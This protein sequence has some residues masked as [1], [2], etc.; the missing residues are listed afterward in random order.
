[1]SPFLARQG[2]EPNTPIELLY[3]S[4][5]QEDLGGVDL[6]D[7]VM[8]NSDRVE[9]L[10]ERTEARLRETAIKRKHTWDKK[11]D[12]IWMR[13]SGSNLKLDSSWEG[14]YTVKKP[15]VATSTKMLLCDE[16]YNLGSCV[17]RSSFEFQFQII[18]PTCYSML[19]ISD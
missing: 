13:K 16:L 7:W 19:A 6:D 14:P 8:M 4:W 11:A 10:R 12:R 18:I 2:W 15:G 1:M 9:E 17:G 5:V 3:R